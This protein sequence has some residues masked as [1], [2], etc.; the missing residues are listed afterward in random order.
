MRT[1]HVVTIYQKDLAAYLF[2][3][4]AHA[5]HVYVEFCSVG[6]ALQIAYQSAQ[7]QGGIPIRGG[8]RFGVFQFDHGALRAAGEDWAG[9]G[10]QL[11]QADQ[12]RQMGRPQVSAHGSS[13]SFDIFNVA[14]LKK[15]YKERG[16]TLGKWSTK[17]DYEIALRVFEE[18]HR[19]Q[20]ARKEKEC[21]ELEVGGSHCILLY[22]AHLAAARVDT[23]LK[24]ELNKLQGRKKPVA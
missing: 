18:D 14:E 19:I 12:D 8:P 9:R 23:V 17:V 20:R 2:C 10:H 6:A 11:A 4:I 13:P 24:L 15:L 16:L 22:K 5:F 1:G 21:D 7:Q 3:T